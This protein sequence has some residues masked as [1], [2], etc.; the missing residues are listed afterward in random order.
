[1]IIL[2]KKVAGYNNYLTLATKDMKFG[3]NENLNRVKHTQ[4]KEDSAI[5][6][7]P[8]TLPVPQTGNENEGFSKSIDISINEKKLRRE[9]VANVRR[10]DYLR[11]FNC[12]IRYLKKFHNLK[13][14]MKILGVFIR[15]RRRNRITLRI[16]PKTCS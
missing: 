6:G 1:M 9:R 5:R 8:K 13:K 4:Q 2:K 3:V 11:I 14:I 15:S 7:D 10:C 12:K 16:I